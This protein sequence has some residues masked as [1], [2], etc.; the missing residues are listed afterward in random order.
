[1]I[2]S[3]T[4]G[5]LLPMMAPAAI[6]GGVGRVY[7]DEVSASFFRFARE[8]PKELRPRRV[9]DAFRKAMIMYHPVH[10]QVFHADDT[11][12]IDNFA[13]LLM[14]EVL[15]PPRNTFMDTGHG[16]A[17]FPTFRST[18]LQSRVFALHLCQCLF[19]LT[20]EARVLNLLPVR[21]GC[22]RLEPYINAHGV[23]TWLKTFRFT[24]NG[25]GY[26]PF[27]SRGASDG[28]G[29]ERAFDRTVIHH[30][31]RPNFRE[32]HTVVMGDTEAR[33]RVGETVVAPISLKA[34]VAGFL[35]SLAPTK[36]RFVCQIDTN[37]HILKDLGIH[38]SEGGAFFFQYRIGLLLLETRKSDA[39][40]LI[41]RI[42]HFEQ[43][44]V[45]DTTLFQVRFQYIQ[46]FLRR[47]NPVLKGFKHVTSIYV[48]RTIVKRE[49]PIFPSHHH[50]E[51][52]FIPA[53]KGRGFLARSL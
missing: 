47:K 52:P 33:L 16:F 29:L 3:D 45:E 21:E 37:R 49:V 32:T 12:L 5:H 39:V 11:E 13:T 51:E 36:E 44:V 31:E 30:L 15:T 27:A 14:G 34:W 38:I 23:R 24:L 6:L 7:F 17:M 2:G 4:Q 41:C 26:V 10:V 48:N 53:L 8:L 19:F 9:T 43:M 22:E 20:E 40:S 35:T 1:M 28:T 18:L 42:A 25:E 46:L 50:K